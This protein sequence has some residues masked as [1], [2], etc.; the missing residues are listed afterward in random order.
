MTSDELDFLPLKVTHIDEGGRRCFDPDGKRRLIEA[1]EKPGASVAGLA[2]K[3]GVN[4]NQL[5]KWIMLER[6]RLMHID[7][8]KSSRTGSA[9]FVP[10][11]EVAEPDAVTASANLRS[12]PAVTPVFRPREVVRSSPRASEPGDEDDADAGPAL[13]DTGLPLVGQPERSKV[14]RKPLPA[15]LKRERVDYD[16]P[17]D[18]RGCPCCGNP[19]HRIG[20][21]ISEQL[22][23]QV[24]WT[25]RQNARAEYACRHCE[26][27][28]EHTPVVLAPMPVQ[29]IPGSHADASVI[30]TVA[31]AKYVDGMPLYRMQ[32]ALARWQIP[33]SRGTLAQ[34]VIRPTSHPIAEL[35]TICG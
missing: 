29:P 6:R 13:P 10:V 8:R 31:T 28:A 5:R 35:R 20:E 4:A 24:K 25:V 23:V 17:E 27:H 9:E 15:Y 1:C 11:V 22:H 12:S 3:A 14:G 16:L 30:A 34:W 32:A 26:R 2:L 7:S 33:V 18:Q 19:M 21:D